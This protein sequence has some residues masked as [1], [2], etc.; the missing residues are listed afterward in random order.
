[1]KILT[2]MWLLD[3]PK[4]PPLFQIIEVDFSFFCYLSFT[5]GIFIFTQAI[6]KRTIFDELSNERLGWAC[7]EHV[8]VPLRGKHP[9]HKA[10]PMPVSGESRRRVFSCVRFL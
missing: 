6:I 10:R 3:P 5:G 4:N 7:I 9:D 2:G 8:V 1:M